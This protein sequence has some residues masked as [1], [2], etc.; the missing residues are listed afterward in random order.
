MCYDRDARPPIAPIAGGAESAGEIILTASDG[1]RFRAY[2]ARAAHPTGAGVVILPDIRGLHP[3]YEELAVRFA[4]NGI[5]ALAMDYFGRTAGT[6]PRGDDFDWQPHVA[7]TRAET[8]AADVAASAAY[9]RSPA[10]GAV[11]SLFTLGFCFG[12]AVSWIQAA[13][14]LGLAGAI[15][16][17]GRPLGP[18]RDGSPAPIDRVREFACPILGLF[19]GADPAIPASAVEAFDRALSEAGIEHE[20]VTYPGAPHSFFDRRQ[21]EFAEAS[22]DAW[23]RVLDFIRSHAG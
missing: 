21:T 19:G 7:Q 15:G 4:E 17:Y 13:N 9:L 6:A 20:I 3:F 5:D 23:R 11:R 2:A 10:G 16:F 8:L 22:A 1:A 18:T 12:G 14:Q